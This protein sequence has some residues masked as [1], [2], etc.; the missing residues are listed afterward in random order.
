M[1]DRRI[2]NKIIFSIVS[3]LCCIVLGCKLSP[4]N[5]ESE[6]GRGNPVLV[7]DKPVYDENSKTFSLMVHA[8]SVSDAQVTYYLLDGDSVLMNTLDGHFTGIAPLEEGYNVK[9]KVEWSDTTITTMA[10]HVVGFII[11]L[12]PIEKLSA[13][14]LKKLFDIKDK[15]SIEKCLA[16][17]IKLVV[18]GSQMTPSMIDEVI[19]NLENHIWS[20]VEVVAMEYDDYNYITFI[21]IKPVGE[22]VKTVS[23]ENESEMFYDEF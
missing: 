14:E 12:K 10:Y 11:P 4:S 19:L 5:S 2:K 17:D 13:K 22:K 16:Q 8:D 3:V 9:A 21:T 18:K 7:I 20:S 6:N 15:A 23:N 1:K